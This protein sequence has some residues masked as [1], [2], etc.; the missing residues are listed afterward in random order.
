MHAVVILASGRARAASLVGARG[1]LEPR[2][3]TGNFGHFKVY[4]PENEAL[5]LSKALKG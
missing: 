4:A 1:E 5:N 3:M 2:P